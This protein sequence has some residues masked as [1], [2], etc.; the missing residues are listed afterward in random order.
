LVLPRL[1]AVKRLENNF[2]KCNRKYEAEPNYVHKIFVENS[3][4]R[5]AKL[6]DGLSVH[7][8]YFTLYVPKIGQV[9]ALVL[10][11]M[12]CHFDLTQRAV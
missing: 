5:A 10:I 11:F 8:S 3:P 12:T 2:Q 4:R 7:V 6:D 1:F 9:M